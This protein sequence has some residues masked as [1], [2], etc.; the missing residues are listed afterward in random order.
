M[1]AP[2]GGWGYEHS[3]GLTAL[4]EAVA[5]TGFLLPAVEVEGAVPEEVDHAAACAAVADPGEARAMLSALIHRERSRPGSLAEPVRR[6]VLRALFRR[7][8]E[9]RA[10]VA[11]W[12][13]AIGR[14]TESPH[15]R[16]PEAA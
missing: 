6:G 16:L 14:F 2:P 15:A 9:L 5:A 7:L 10:S 13:S 8:D 11:P 12:I 4:F 3:P 1:P